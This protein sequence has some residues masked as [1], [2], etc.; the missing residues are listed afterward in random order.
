M[1]L[2][3]TWTMFLCK[4]GIKELKLTQNQR[5]G[6]AIVNPA[7]HEIPILFQCSAMHTLYL[8]NPPHANRR[9]GNRQLEISTRE[10]LKSLNLLFY[11]FVSGHNIGILESQAQIWIYTMNL[12]KSIHSND[13]QK[14]H[15][16]RISKNQY[17][18]L[19]TIS[20]TDMWYMFC[21]YTLL[22]WICNHTT[23]LPRH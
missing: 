19:T 1:Q 3:N 23:A 6:R 11:V 9:S 8:M 4:N 21:L 14:S 16:T 10:I 17:V 22:E 7:C 15:N 12:Y 5:A 18:M 2:R 20:T 13:H